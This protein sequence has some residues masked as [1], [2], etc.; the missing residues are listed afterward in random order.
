MWYYV[1]VP[2]IQIRRLDK[3]KNGA[4]QLLTHDSGF[5]AMQSVV[6]VFYEDSSK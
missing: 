3:K 4:L 6:A 5:R 1:V 2:C